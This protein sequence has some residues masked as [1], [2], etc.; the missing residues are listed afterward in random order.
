VR[1]ERLTLGSVKPI[2]RGLLSGVG[3]ALLLLAFCPVSSWAAYPGAN[4]R[5][6]YGGQP[7]DSPY[8]GDDIY[9]VLPDGTAPQRLTTNP[10]LDE[11]AP[12]WSSNGR[13]LAFTRAMPSGL[14]QIFTIRADGSAETRV[15]QD[16]YTAGSPYFSPGGLWIVYTSLQGGASLF[17]IRADGTERRRRIVKGGFAVEPEYGPR[18]KR[19]VFAGYPQGRGDGIWTVHPD[20]SHRRRLTKPDR[21]RYYDRDPDFS[22][23]GRHITFSRCDFSD[24]AYE[25]C[26]I[27]LM[28]ADG[29]Y[30][31]SIEDP[32]L[33]TTVHGLA[34]SPVGDRIAFSVRPSHLDLTYSNV[35]TI[36][37]DGSDP[38]AVTDNYDEGEASAPSWQPVLGG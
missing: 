26:E 35:Y 37:V 38:Q 10:E 20:G 34:Y 23:D 29:S 18:G 27:Y 31:H 13:R 22:P 19:I 15:T 5:I 12:A 36:A 2:R 3:V 14:G 17:K 28:R 33:G 9:T 16:R 11:F 1:L 4:G 25:D 21:R 7:K 30:Q 6:A 32:G 24:P 8:K